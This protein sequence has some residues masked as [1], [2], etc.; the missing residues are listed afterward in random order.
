MRITPA[1]LASRF[2]NA[3]QICTTVSPGCV[4]ADTPL[5]HTSTPLASRTPVPFFI[6]ILL[7]SQSFAS[8]PFWLR[9]AAAEVPSSLVMLAKRFWLQ[10]DA[11]SLLLAF[12][13]P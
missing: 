3:E 12:D 13:K 10:F 11:P 8:E 4:H 7:L 6:W 9:T 5:A 2:A 1:V